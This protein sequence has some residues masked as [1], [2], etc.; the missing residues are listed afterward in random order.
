[1]DT[2]AVNP[3]YWVYP[4]S[5]LIGSL[6]SAYLLGKI[7]KVDI[8]KVGSGNVGAT[9]AARILGKK[10]A[11]IVLIMDMLKGFFSVWLAKYF[12]GINAENPNL[13]PGMLAGFFCVI[14]HIFPVWLKFK[15]GKGVA[16]LCGIVIALSP[17]QAF[18]AFGVFVLTLYL[19]RFVSLSSMLGTVSLP[20]SYFVFFNYATH[21]EL[22]YFFITLTLIIL[23]MHSG[24][25]KRLMSGTESKIST[26]AK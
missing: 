7:K 6:P 3:E 4:L 5:Y 15:G 10:T 25:I 16:T 14:G 23:I 24:N 17:V 11:S 9:N 22:F 13:L 20:F 21:P 12:L 19:S 26:F 1:M 2:L 18:V 8:R